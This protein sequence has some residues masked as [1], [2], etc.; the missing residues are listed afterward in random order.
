MF[1]FRDN[2]IVIRVSD[3]M[4]DMTASFGRKF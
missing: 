3:V 4:F 1:C 2:A